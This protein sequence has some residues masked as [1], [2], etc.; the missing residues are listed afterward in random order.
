[1]NDVTALQER[2]RLE[3]PG[4]QVPPQGTDLAPL[5]DVSAVEVSYGDVRALRGVDLTVMPGQIV[6]L[7][8]RNGAGKS[9]LVSVVGGLRR[10]DAGTCRISG[11]DTATRGGQARRGL[12]LAPQDIGIYPTLSVKDNLVFFGRIAGLRGREKTNRRIGDIA[13]ALSVSHLLGRQ[14]RTLSGGEKRRVHVAAAL[15][16]NPPLVVLDEP[17]AGADIDTRNRLLALVKDLSA[18]GT[19]VLYSTHYLPEIEVLGS[20]VVILEAGKVL[21]EGQVDELVKAHGESSVEMAFDGA[22]PLIDWAPGTIVVGTR[23]TVPT[24]HPASTVAELTAAVATHDAKLL[25]V[26]IIRPSL[27]S[28]FTAVVGAH[29]DGSDDN[30][31]GR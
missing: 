22:P 24:R 15:L 13:E 10:P 27:E 31:G 20:T 18:A 26:E 9:T 17:T 5:L 30:E 28:V 2:S 14:A 23:V 25:S 8:G 4:Q 29:A 12:G 1:M 7:L 16:H 19:G 6:G 21:V 11:I 3:V